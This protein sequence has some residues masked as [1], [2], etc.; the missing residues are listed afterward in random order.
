[1]SLIDDLLTAYHPTTPAPPRPVQNGPG[2]PALPTAILTCMDARI[3]TARIL[4]PHTGAGPLIGMIRNAGGR[5]SDDAVRSLVVATRLRGVRNLLVVHHTDCALL[6]F[7]NEEMHRRLAEETGDDTAG[8]DFLPIT[9]LRQSVTEDVAY[10]S[11][12]PL[13]AGAIRVSGY[14][15]DL[16]TGAVHP[17]THR[18]RADISG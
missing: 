5:A 14:I 16:E 12:H 6:T 15:Y 8:F 11:A 3:D 1:M 2:E 13:F 18:A 10:L 9:T 4:G 7:T 17:V